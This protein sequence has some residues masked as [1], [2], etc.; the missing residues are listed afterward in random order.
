[1][2]A[3]LIPESMKTYN[4]PDIQRVIIRPIV[5]ITPVP[6]HVYHGDWQINNP[7]CKNL[8][9]VITSR[10]DV[11]ST[12]DK[13]NP[14]FTPTKFFPSKHSMNP[15]R[16]VPNLGT[17]PLGKHAPPRA[18]IRENKASPSSS[19]TNFDHSF[20]SRTI[21]IR[22]TI[23]MLALS[24]QPNDFARRCLDGQLRRLWTAAT[25]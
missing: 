24:G 11:L 18:S 25:R 22:T 13:G 16:S 3:I 23:H 19:F 8:C 2:M 4:V 5:Y 6:M 9:R 10:E 15:E 21:G 17:V 12:R 14:T 7:Q 1:M 20:P